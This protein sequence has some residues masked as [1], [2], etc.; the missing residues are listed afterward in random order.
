MSNGTDTV[1]GAPSGDDSDGGPECPDQKKSLACDMSQL[2]VFSKFFLS[3][4][5]THSSL[6]RCTLRL[7]N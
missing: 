7:E 3:I 2:P 1:G 4:V 6:E 5:A